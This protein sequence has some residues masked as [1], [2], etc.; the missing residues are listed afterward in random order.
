MKKIYFSQMQNTT[1]GGKEVTGVGVVDAVSNCMLDAYS[2][3][4]FASVLLGF[5]TFVSYGGAT[6]I[7]GAACYSKIHR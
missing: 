7:V 2:G 1:G 3:H 6:L 5:A 4:G